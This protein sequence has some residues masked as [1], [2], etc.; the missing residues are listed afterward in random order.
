MLLAGCNHAASGIGS[1]STST[2]SGGPPAVTTS[3]TGAPT[4][5]PTPTAAPS[6]S[7]RVLVNLKCRLPVIWGDFG[8]AT[9]T[10]GFLSF[11]TKTLVRD[12]TAPVGS[13]FYDRAYSKW[14]PT[15][16][17]AVS[18]D[19]SRFAYAKGDS[20]HFPT[21]GT[22]HVVDVSTGADHIIYSG[23]PMYNVVDFA[24]EGIYVTSADSE[25]PVGLLLMNPVGGKPRLIS[26]TILQPALGNGAAWGLGFN[27][28]DPH[29]G[30]GGMIGPQNEVLRF[31]LGTGSATRWLYKPGAS[32]EILGF[33]NSGNLFL[34][35]RID[36]YKDEIL[37]VAADATSRVVFLD[38]NTQAEHQVPNDIAAV[39]SYGTWFNG[40]SQDA[41]PDTSVWLAT[42]TRLRQVAT[43]GQNQLFIAGGCI[44]GGS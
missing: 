16:R 14:L 35:D 1:T 27:S 34:S 13:D 40:L 38:A 2:P 22:L 11:S 31:D 15:W 23:S 36:L 29:P 10:Y 33:D 21:K 7:V 32:F 30:V 4:A 42:G 28:A 5:A 41:G 26:R 37:K 9:S 18:P 39:D 12:S 25:V 24:A 8:A 44:P 6:T 20:T 17:Y 3:P 43:I 19:G